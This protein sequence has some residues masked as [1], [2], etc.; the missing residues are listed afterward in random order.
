M[1]VMDLEDELWKARHRVV[2]LETALTLIEG[3]RRTGVMRLPHKIAPTGG[4]HL[5]RR[6]ET[7]TDKRN[8]AGV[9]YSFA[10]RNVAP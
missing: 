10:L 5:E 1:T 6:L 2:V 4:Y 8:V 7:E 9:A 3:Y